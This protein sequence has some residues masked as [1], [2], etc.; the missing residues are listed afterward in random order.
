S[1]TGCPTSST[2]APA[3]VTIN[4]AGPVIWFVNSAA[5][6]NGNGTLGSPFNVLASA[7]AADAA[8]QG[9]FLYSSATSYTGALTLNT[10][11]QLIGQPTTGTT[12][13]SVFGITPPAATVA[14]PTLGSGTATLTGTLTLAG[15]ATLRGLALSTAASSGLVASG[16]LTGI[17]VA[18]TSVTTTTG[19]AVNL[20]NA[21]GT[22]TFSSV[23]TNGAANGILLDTLGSS[24]VTVNGGAI[25]NASTR[26]IDINSGTGNYSFANT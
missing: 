6:T 12:F 4:V 21:T 19:T 22:Y 13:D 7:D 20:N 11:E 2:S 26:G 9:I 5:A 25:V 14:R 16:G 24:P 1:D 3:T 10:G 8:N 15:T 18:Q 23:S 17:D